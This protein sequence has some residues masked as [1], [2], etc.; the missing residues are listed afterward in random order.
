MG[1]GASPATTSGRSEIAAGKRHDAMRLHAGSGC[2]A[3]PRTEGIRDPIYRPLNLPASPI[4]DSNRRFF[5]GIWLG[6]GLAMLWLVPSIEHQGV[7]DHHWSAA[8][9]VHAAGHSSR[10]LPC[11]GTSHALEQLASA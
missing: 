2:A 8:G 7:L 1:R 6:R 3:C 5:G 4:L 10:G 11:G 9:A